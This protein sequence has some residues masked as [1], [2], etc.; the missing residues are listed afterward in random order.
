M[1]VEF[2][3]ACDRRFTFTEVNKP[4]YTNEGAGP[5]CDAC[6]FFV[7]HIEEL[8]DRVTDLEKKLRE[9]VSTP[10]PYDLGARGRVKR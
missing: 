2:C 5:F 8:R 6:W 1:T 3:F 10:S 9:P 4:N 7:G